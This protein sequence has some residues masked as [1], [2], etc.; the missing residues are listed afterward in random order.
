MEGFQ[1]FFRFPFRRKEAAYDKHEKKEDDFRQ[2][3]GKSFI[4]NG[5]G[6][7]E[8]EDGAVR[9]FLGIVALG[10]VIGIPVH[11]IAFALFHGFFH[12]RSGGV[13]FILVVTVVND[14]AVPVKPYDMDG[15]VIVLI[16]PGKI[17]LPRFLVVGGYGPCHDAVQV[18]Q[19]MAEL[20]L[21]ALVVKDGGQYE[22]DNHGHDAHEKK[23]SIDADFHNNAPVYDFLSPRRYPTPRTVRMQAP[24]LPSFCR[25]L[26]MCISMVLLSISKGESQTACMIWSLERTMPLFN[27]K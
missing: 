23:A 5:T 22:C 15:F 9:C 6:A 19:L 17:G 10:V 12:F 24:S 4:G 14:A 27:N 8:A 16:Y 1:D 20:F 7:G 25:R 13:V 18:L 2:V 26:M 21:H 11:R 3:G